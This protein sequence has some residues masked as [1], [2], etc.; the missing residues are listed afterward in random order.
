MLANPPVV[1]WLLNP[2][3]WLLRPPP[4]APALLCAAQVYEAYEAEHAAKENALVRQQAKAR[5]ANKK[6]VRSLNLALPFHHPLLPPAAPRPPE[7]LKPAPL[8]GGGAAADA[9]TH[10][11]HA[12]AAV[13][14]QSCA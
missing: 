8:R 2:L 11:N 1:T 12:A 10:T 14:G 5:A 6:Q 4:P 9:W 7:A 13:P 3:W